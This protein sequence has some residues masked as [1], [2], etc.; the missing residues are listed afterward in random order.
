MR[1]ILL[2]GDF[3]PPWGGISTQIATLQDRLLARGDE[4]VVLD[5]GRHRRRAR[6]GCLPARGATHF[7]TTVVQHARRGFTVHL[8]TNGHNAKSWLATF[9]CAVAG[10]GAGRHTVVS[11]G[12]GLMPSFL[13]RASALVRALAR[14]SLRTAGACI[15]RNESAH[16]AL[17]NLGADPAKLRVLSGFYGVAPQDIGPVPRAAARVRRGHRPLIG[18]IA[19][20]GPEYGLALAVDAAA[21]LR[22]RYP[23]LGLVLLGP[24][25][26]PD[27]HPI[28]TFPLGELDRPALLAA[29][30]SLDVFVRP[31]YF[32]GDASSVREALAMGVRVVASD[33]EL[34]PAGVHTFP[35][36][37][38]DALATAIERALMAMPVKAT[39][40]SLAALLEI[41]DALPLGGVCTTRPSVEAITDAARC[42]LGGGPTSMPGESRVA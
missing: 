19:T 2:V 25:C 15:V 14:T 41:Y 21:R 7:A 30:R 4:V 33:E 37:D 17:V 1:R 18:V 31:T 38:A 13:R 36:G 16:A 9:A 32:D 24:D 28:W 5:I 11:L 26:L 35:K 22:P 3:P 29:M 27:G 39:S 8:H 23:E 40:S 12:S 6:P 42:E 10:A 20:P 34:R